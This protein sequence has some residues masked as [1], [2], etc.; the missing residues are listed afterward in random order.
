M[1]GNSDGWTNKHT[2]RAVLATHTALVDVPVSWTWRGFVTPREK[3][4]LT[5]L[6]SV[7]SAD[8]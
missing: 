3:F 4:V 1:V 7:G 2:D 5:S 8:E 6:L